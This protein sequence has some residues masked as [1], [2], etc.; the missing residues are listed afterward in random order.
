MHRAP[1]PAHTTDLAAE[2]LSQHGLESGAERQ[3]HAM[4][5]VGAG[6]CVGRP[7]GC[8]DP[9]TNSFLALR[10]VR[11]ARDEPLTEQLEHPLFGKA[12]LDHPRVAF[13]P[14]RLTAA[15]RRSGC[16]YIDDAR[17]S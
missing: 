9:D 4:A 7:G 10:G 14:A 15:R 11:G 2:D 17:R 5:P 12:D 8:R 6:D 13:D 16:L 3:S 1:E